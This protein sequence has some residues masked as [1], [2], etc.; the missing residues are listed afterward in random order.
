[1]KTFKYEAATREGTISS[2]IIE[3]HNRD[4]A[5][6]KLRGD[7]FIV[8]SLDEVGAQSSREIK[9]GG[10]KVK[11]KQLSLICNQFAIILSSGLPIV[12]TI[13]LV[14]NQ[15]ENRRM[16][17]I[18]AD[19][20]ADVSVGY[21]LA[22]S[23]ANHGK[24]L[25]TTFIETV[26]AGEQSGDLAEVFRSLSEY[27]EQRSRTHG[28]VISALIYPAFV[29]GIAIVVVAIIMVFAVPMFKSTF[30]SMGTELPW[31]TKALI[32]QSDFFVHWTWLVALIIIALIVGIKMWKK[33]EDGRLKIARFNLKVPIAGH[34]ALMSAS[35]QYAS[36]MAIMLN[37]GLSIINSVD[38]TGRAMSNYALGSKLRTI[39]PDLESGKQ[40]GPS[41]AK[42]EAFPDLL[43][44]MSAVGEESGSLES[45]LHTL[46]VYYDN[47]VSVA[48]ARALSV[49]EPVI[50]VILAVFVVGILFSVY[51]PMFSMYGGITG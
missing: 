9:I 2:G 37:A 36:T 8:N 6:V 26:R 21:G 13:E 50:I 38:V 20:A 4:E 51:L 35:Q 29:I 14:G 23:F 19:V 15:T 25:P 7:F 34:I 11:D 40:L 24:E 1:M 46:S 3:A 49:L 45:T 31:I 47:E 10:G 28:K 12:R 44:E 33:R 41:L 17:E 18:L 39:I 42:L 27:F 5:L 22:D 43:V 16:K 30:E 32:A 48:T